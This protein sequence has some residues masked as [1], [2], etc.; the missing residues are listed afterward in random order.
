MFLPW[1]VSVSI[2]ISG[3]GGLRSREGILVLG[4]I[5]CLGMLVGLIPA[6]SVR[7]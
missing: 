6:V 4:G 7:P 5:P 3:G 2:W 1:F